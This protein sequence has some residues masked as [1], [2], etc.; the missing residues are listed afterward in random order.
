MALQSEIQI[1]IAGNP[2]TAFQEF[3]LHQYLGTHHNFELVC[4][5]DVLEKLKGG[6]A[7]ETKNYLGESFSAQVMAVG[8]FTGYKE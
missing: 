7:E 5:M 4:R 2:I 6:L 1:Y 8:A 3:T